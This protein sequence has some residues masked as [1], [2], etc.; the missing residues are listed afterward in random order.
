MTT[1]EATTEDATAKFLA[2]AARLLAMAVE[3]DGLAAKLNDE[4]DR[5]SCCTTARFRYWPQRQ[6]KQR[7]NGT[8]TR[9]R[10]IAETLN[11]RAADPDFINPGP[12]PKEEGPACPACSKPMRAVPSE[13]ARSRFVTGVYICSACG[14]KEALEGQHWKPSLREAQAID[15]A[16]NLWIAEARG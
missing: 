3:V 12:L 14:T 5:C 2:M 8:A 1:T 16:Q 13:N 11:R 10:E 4:A 6:L 15:A 9:L 7:V